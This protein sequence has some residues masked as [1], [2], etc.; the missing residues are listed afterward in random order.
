MAARGVAIWIAMTWN[1]WTN[2]RLTFSYG[3]KG[4]LAEQYI[5]FVLSC[6]LGAMFSWSISV[7]LASQIVMFMT[8]PIIA[9]II[10][11]M[12]GTTTNYLLSRFW[13]FKKK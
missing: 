8:H 1:F 13:V 5:R 10:G 3:R 2:R 9:A 6:G 11:V 4:K 12:V 7:S